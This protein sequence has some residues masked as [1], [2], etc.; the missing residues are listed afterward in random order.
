MSGA[1]STNRANTQF[2]SERILQVRPVRMIRLEKP[3]AKKSTVDSLG[4]RH[5]DSQE[6]EIVR[7]L[8][9]NP[10]HSDNQVARLAG[11]PVMTV[12][13]K[14]KR[15]EQEGLLRYYAELDLTSGGLG[16]YPARQLHIIKF[17]E[18]ITP[19]FFLQHSYEEGHAKEHHAKNI[20]ESE[21]AEVDGHLALILEI[22]GRNDNEIV[23][24]FN[25]RIIPDFKAK[26]GENCIMEIKTIRLGQTFRL[27]HNYLPSQN[28]E[29]GT[30][31]K[32]WRD[33]WVF[34]DAD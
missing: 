1:V 28:M 31:K 23:E 2:E 14:R 21:L 27:L 13:R 26:F 16:L 6:R 30:M 25:G 7:Q 10:R 12:N 34:V 33:E 29:H 18:G 9:K 11:I 17:R 24:V 5:L 3:K 4:H 22:V 20:F 32:S 15:L 8:I 19:K